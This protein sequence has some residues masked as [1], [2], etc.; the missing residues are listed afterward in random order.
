MS[1]FTLF[2]TLR[3]GGLIGHI[4]NL[5]LLGFSLLS[6]AIIFQ[7]SSAFR[8]SAAEN[9]QFLALYWK[10]ADLIELRKAAMRMKQ[11][12]V[13][14]V[15]LS[16]LERLDPDFSLKTEDDLKGMEKAERI[17]TIKILERTLRRAIEEQVEDLEGYLVFLATTGNVAPLLGLL[18]TVLGIISAF[19]GISREGTAGIAAVAPG[20]ALA[21][22]TT[23]AGL[24]AAIP[25]VMA[26]NH[27][28]N[29]VRRMASEMESFS[30]EFLS[31][32]EERVVQPKSLGKVSTA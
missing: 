32:V 7:K 11:S 10:V 27:Y 21:L 28:N 1:D 2:Q 25:A 4:I 12:P 17:A 15:F 22:S 5:V 13:A 3:S 8:R 6:W 19:H 24:L 30:T 29:R 14:R 26:F 20:V 18:G 23:A 9:K 31:L 16:G